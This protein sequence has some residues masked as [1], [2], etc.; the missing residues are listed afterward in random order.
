MQNLI[1]SFVLICFLSISALAQKLTLK[2]KS[3]TLLRVPE[4]VLF[5]ATRNKLYVANID[6][7]PWEK[8]GK[9]SIGVLT[10]DGKIEKVEWV[11]GL[12]APKGMGLYKNNLYVADISRVIVIDVTSGKITEK[13]EIDG[14]K[15]LN[16]V[17]VSKSGQVYISD[18][19]SGKVYTINKGKGELYFESP[20][21]KGTNG[22]LAI[23]DGLYLV[24]FANGQNWK[25]SKDKKL[26]KV[27]TTAEQADGV[28]PVGNN[29]Y[30]V[31]S[32]G[33]KI[34]YVNAKGESTKILD[35]TAE[36][37]SSADIEYDPKSKTL[38]VPTFF[39]NGVMAYTFEK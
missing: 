4:S 27:C 11:T 23:S 32:W 1:L 29:D 39:K 37:I 6:G 17:T 16:D 30:L 8:D 24:D 26:T 20:E 19:G 5:D 10:T 28:V 2:W 22:V 38:Y 3:D 7:G 35:T 18:S 15:N 21:L 36:K 33:G 9:G 31:S 34:F 12:D 14:T 13:I 25:L